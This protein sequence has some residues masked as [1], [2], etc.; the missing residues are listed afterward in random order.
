MVQPSR[1]CREAVKAFYS[2]LER[3][4]A[5]ACSGPH[6]PLE[7]VMYELSKSI[8]HAKHAMHSLRNIELISEGIDPTSLMPMS[9]PGV[10]SLVERLASQ[11]QRDRRVADPKLPPVTRAKSPRD[12][13][14]FFAASATPPAPRSTSSAQP[15]Q[16]TASRPRLGG[17]IGSTA[18][19]PKCTPPAAATSPVEPKSAS[20]TASV[21]KRPSLQST[22][23]TLEKLAELSGLTVQQM[24]HLVLPASQQ[25]GT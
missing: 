10:Q 17:G 8:E 25:S 21:S 15:P 19:R 23:I 16:R 20:T 6:K 9:R 18:A 7:R 1:K 4:F 24:R 22:G 2:E 5:R 14:T 13:R 12:S 11:G 3:P